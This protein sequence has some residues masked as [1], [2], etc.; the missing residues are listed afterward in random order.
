MAVAAATEIRGRP[1]A[2]HPQGQDNC[3]NVSSYW[4]GWPCLF[5]QHGPGRKHERR[6]VLTRWQEELAKR[7]PDELLRGLI[8]SDGCRFM[9]TGRGN[10]VCPRYSFVQT[11]DDIRAIFCNACD[12]LGV[13][14]TKSGERTIYVSC[15]ADVAKLDEFIGPKR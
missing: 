4:K 13:H 6:I 3:V 2:V 11:S 10:W 15:K 12:L 14:W 1:A 5:P 7:W 9:N 8:H